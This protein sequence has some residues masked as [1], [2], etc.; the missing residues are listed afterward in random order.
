[1]LQ[2]TGDLQLAVVLCMCEESS[3]KCRDQVINSPHR[4]VQTIFNFI[5]LVVGFIWG[6]CGFQSSPSDNPVK[7]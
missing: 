4:L 7:Q 6:K 2:F 1:M 5:V 3:H